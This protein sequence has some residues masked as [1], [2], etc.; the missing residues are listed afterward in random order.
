MSLHMAT[1]PDKGLI[2]A[3]ALLT[4]PHA[5]ALPSSQAGRK[6][7]LARSQPF[8]HRLVEVPSTSP[9]SWSLLRPGKMDV[10]SFSGD[11]DQIYVRYDGS[12]LGAP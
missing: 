7:L 3:H 6:I 10:N 9:V 8:I 12:T 4:K 5:V 1:Q 11:V 2:V